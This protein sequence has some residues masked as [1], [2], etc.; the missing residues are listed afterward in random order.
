MKRNKFW[1]T[2]LLLIAALLFSV[3]SCEPKRLREAV[4]DLNDFSFGLSV[5]RLYENELKKEIS[6]KYSAYS[7]TVFNYKQG[8][9][10]AVAVKY[11]VSSVKSEGPFAKFKN[12][13]FYNMQSLADVNDN[14]MMISA[15]AKCG[16]GD[17]IRL[18]NDLKAAYGKPVVKQHIASFTS[19][20]WRIDD[21]TIQ[22]QLEVIPDYEN[23]K[24]K[25]S[26]Y[27]NPNGG[28]LK[29]DSY[30]P[31]HVSQM[32]IHIFDNDFIQELKEQYSYAENGHKPYFYDYDEKTVSPY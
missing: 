15:D 17:E 25:K 14:L 18:L 31:N 1:S 24:N 2:K 19:F 21:R 30:E 8:I 12:V 29:S 5:N 4:F 13:S 3:A 6:L 9:Q 28:F 22:I 16:Y 26:D 23:D 11:L 32:F 20:T 10:K 27:L 7:D